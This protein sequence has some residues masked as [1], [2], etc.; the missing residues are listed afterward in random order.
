M[1]RND[2]RIIYMRKPVDQ[3]L[4]RMWEFPLTVVEAPMGYGKT[5]AVKEYLKSSHAEVLWQTL[6]D[7][8]AT[9]FWQGFSRLFRKSNPAAAD[10]L[11][12]LGAPSNSVFLAE[13]IRILEEIEFSARTVIVFDDFHLLSSQDIDRFVEL[14][15]RHELPNL[16]IV[17]ISRSVFGENTAELVLKGYCWV[18][19]KR[20]FELSRDEI[21]EYCG[22]WGVKLNTEETNFLVSYTEGWISAIY[23]CLLGFLQDGRIEQQV[24]LYELI[25]KVVYRRISAEAQEFLL[26]I[27]IFDSFSLEQAE[28]MWHR[29]NVEA[30]LRQLAAENAFIR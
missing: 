8:S 11:A 7:D 25:E 16:H 2:A 21:I 19:A 4:N 23:L 22:L 3:A 27:C 17:I 28:Y 18:I 5:I 14:L 15:V 12:G 29:D 20:C 10:S 13:A 30:L 26:N 9:V 6:V 1:Y 24:T